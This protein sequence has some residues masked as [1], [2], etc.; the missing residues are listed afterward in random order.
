[1][2]RYRR[3]ARAAQIV[4]FQWLA[5]QQLDGR[6]LPARRSPDGARRALVLTAHDI[7]PREPRRGQLAAQRRLYGRVDAVIVHSER[8]RERLLGLGV[9]PRRV[10]VIAHGV[11]RPWQDRAAGAGARAGGDRAPRL[12]P[13]L[14]GDGDA[15]V[16][17]FAG[18]LREY[19]GLAQLLEAWQGAGAQLPAGV[20]LWIVGMPRMDLAPLRAGARAAA[21]AGAGPVRLVERFVSDDELHAL[22][23]RA[24]LVVLPYRE[25]DH[26]GVAFTALGAGV[27]L[28]LSDVGGFPEIARTGAAATFAAGDAAELAGALER[29]LGDRQTLCAMAE[30][31]RAAAAG[32]Y[33][34]ETIARRTLDLYE[35]LL[36]E[37]PGR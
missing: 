4:H 2:L 23:R 27:P 25:I 17:L 34:W 18:L 13:E 11:L 30:R 20:E 15:R 28:L 32:P 14:G 3:A 36:R 37:N 8:G 6:L 12:P 21:R 33:A 35:R 26:S 16:V 1:M 31:A 7:L 29:L 22:M 19:K 10:H 5:L 24:E 9:D